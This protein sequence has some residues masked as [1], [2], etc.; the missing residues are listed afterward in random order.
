[1]CII[2]HCSFHQPI[3]GQLRS[4]F[5]PICNYQAKEEAF[6]QENFQGFLSDANYGFASVN[7]K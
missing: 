7:P 6:F 5:V 4:T 1:M 3:T 2:Y